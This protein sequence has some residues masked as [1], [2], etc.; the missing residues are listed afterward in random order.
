MLGNAA[1]D[2]AVI[3]EPVPEPHGNNFPPRRAD[4]RAERGLRRTLPGRVELPGAD[5]EL[6]QPRHVG[7]GGRDDGD[8]GPAVAQKVIPGA[9]ELALGFLPAPPVQVKLAAPPGLVG[10]H[11][12]AEHR[13]VKSIRHVLGRQD[14]HVRQGEGHLGP[15]VGIVVDKGQGIGGDVQSGKDASDRC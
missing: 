2:N 8:L 11:V 3:A 12:R 13:P 14:K 5:G 10:H 7:L 4:H 1:A 6:M 15:L 9:A